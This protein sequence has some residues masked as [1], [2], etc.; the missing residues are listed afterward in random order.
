MLIPILLI[1]LGFVL[2]LK[3]G[4]LFVDSAAW[5]AEVSGIPKFIIGVTLVSFATTLPE[6]LVSM[7]AV[8]SGYVSL[9][10]G[11]AVG[12]T[13]CNAG[14]VLAL[15]ILSLAGKVDDYK[16]FYIKSA[17]LLGAFVM[18]FLF[19]FNDLVLTKFDAALIF[20]I[21]IFFIYYNYMHMKSKTAS[22]KCREDYVPHDKKQMSNKVILLFVSAF[23]LVVGSRLLVDNATVIAEAMQIPHQIIGLTVIALGTSLPELATTLTS[24]KKKEYSMSLGNIMGANILN[25]TL[26]LPLC[27]FIS[28]NGLVIDP[29]QL[30]MFTQP[31]AQTVWIDLPVSFALS[32]L[33][34]VPTIFQK[35][36][37]KWQ[38]AVMLI[39]Y[40]SYM[41]FLAINA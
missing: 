40:F 7:M 13:I 2:L 26:I 28:S 18:L 32:I 33:F 6:L 15:S 9:G 10:I 16:S 39:I 25:L 34:I 23:G 12:S 14:L 4:D 29:Q 3:C 24:I 11:N 19:T 27:T 21:F 8:T 30:D 31:I 38:G 37:R 20:C 22:F 5:I 36:F 41:A 1:I 17:M 35:R